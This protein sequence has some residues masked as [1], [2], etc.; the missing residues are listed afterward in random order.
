MLSQ[1]R[2]STIDIFF[3]IE[4]KTTEG[5]RSVATNLKFDSAFAKMK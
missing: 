2:S 4:S 5:V 1:S 3:E